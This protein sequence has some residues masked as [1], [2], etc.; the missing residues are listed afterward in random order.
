[1]AT[2]KSVAEEAVRAALA[3]ERT[4]AMDPLELG[5]QAHEDGE[6]VAAFL[7]AP[8]V[9]GIEERD[10]ESE[11]GTTGR[12]VDAHLVLLSQLVTHLSARRGESTAETGQW[13]ALRFED[14]Q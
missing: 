11:F 7:V 6:R 5:P 13:L 8:L 10:F 4:K 3:L 14:Y 12:A 2:G 9:F 1:M